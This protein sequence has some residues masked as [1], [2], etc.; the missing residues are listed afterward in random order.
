LS[1]TK[2]PRNSHNLILKDSLKCHP[3]NG[4]SIRFWKDLWFG[5]EHLCTRYNRL[6]R[7]DLNEDCLLCERFNEGSSNWQ[8]LRPITSGRTE[9]KLHSFQSELAVVTLSSSY[10]SWKWNIR[11][12]GSFSVASTQTHIDHYMLPSLTSTTTWI[13]CL[14]RKV[15][16]FLWRFNLDRLPH[17]LNLSKHGIKIGSIICPICNNNME[18]AE[19]IFFSCKMAAQI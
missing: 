5:E 7:L 16:I 17:R 14:P 2:L 10:D 1:A 9:S 3:G 12:D 15:N 4:A 13:A 18:S 11:N 8:R 19:H 6:F